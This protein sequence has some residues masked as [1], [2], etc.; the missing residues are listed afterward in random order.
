M[1]F[2]FK[3]ALEADAPG[4]ISLARAT[5]PEFEAAVRT[6]TQEGEYAYIL[7]LC[8]IRLPVYQ[9]HWE[10]QEI[11]LC[12]AMAFMRLARSE[13]YPNFIDQLSAK[14]RVMFVRA[15]TVFRRIVADGGLVDSKKHFAFYMN[16]ALAEYYVA[17]AAGD[18]QGM[19]K[20][21]VDLLSNAERAA[22]SLG[23]LTELK[24][25]R[26]LFFQG[27]GEMVGLIRL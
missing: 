22:R 14:G 26:E 9:Y 19:K 12:Q 23:E 27:W 7:V 13:E 24:R 15:V 21:L 1:D 18:V 4:L 6:L 17:H 2:M 20:K 16:M 25:L 10:L 3:D 5:F 8:A 11:R